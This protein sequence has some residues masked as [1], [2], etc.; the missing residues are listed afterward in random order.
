MS[1]GTQLPKNSTLVRILNYRMKKYFTIYDRYIFKQVFFATLV[2]ILLF[3]VVWMAPEM[4]LNT[5]KHIFKNEY[6]VRKGMMLLACEIPKILGKAFPVGLLLGSLFTF[7]KLSKDSELTIF[8]AVGMSFFRIIAPLLVLSFFVTILCYITCDK[9]IPYSCNKIQEI[10]EREAVTQFIYS[11]RD[12]NNHPRHAVIVSKFRKGIMSDVIVMDFAD[13]VYTDLHGLENVMVGETGIKT[14][15]EKGEPCWKLTNVI[16]YDI[17]EDGV[18][19]NIRK[20]DEVNVLEGE[21][22]ENAYTLM[23]YSTKRDRDI[24]NRDLRKYVALLK[25]ENMDEQYRAMKNKYLQ[26]FLHPFVCILLAVL[27]ALL[28]FSKPRE[29]KFIGFLIAVGC[30]FL[31]YITL[32]FFDWLAEKGVLTP[33]IAASLPPLAFFAAIVAFYKSKDL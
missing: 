22:A 14:V 16:S 26:R 27:G 1:Q 28:G 7:D 8:R 3:M 31:Y 21:V 19:D 20:L 25:Q 10:K 29:Q 33:L 18:F 13:T 32:P 30:I 23:Q 9:L 5:I 15:N 2:A 6:T 24:N 11:L 12:S 4:L 17:F